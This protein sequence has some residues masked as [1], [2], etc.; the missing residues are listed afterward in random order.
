MFPS[1]SL[2]LLT[3]PVCRGT[4]QAAL[5][6]PSE[7]AAGREQIL[8]KWEWMNYRILQVMYL[9]IAGVFKYPFNTKMLMWEH[10]WRVAV[11]LV[12]ELQSSLKTLREFSFF[13]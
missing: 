6:H 7:A 9:Y 1:P 3:W 8:Q 10:F 5:A 2:V 11:P 4:A 13:N 12:L